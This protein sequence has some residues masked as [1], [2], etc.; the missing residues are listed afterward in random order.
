MASPAFA[1]APASACGYPGDQ[2]AAETL[3]CCP[4]WPWLEMPEDGVPFDFVQFIDTPAAN[5]IE[6][7]IFSFRVPE[8]YR[9]V[10]KLYH[11]S[12]TG[13]GFVEG[14]GN[15]IWRIRQ[16]P[17][18]V[19]GRAVRN[20]ADMRTTRGSLQWQRVLP[21]GIILELNEFATYTVTHSIGSPIVPGGTRIVATLSGWFWP[22]GK[23]S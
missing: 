11:H 21:G 16:G 2:V 13:P 20:L 4:P 23:N 14:S 7:V 17:S 1:Y 10:I 19:A 22:A 9:G 15:L 6:T 18:G 3:N 5:G 8:G 12:F